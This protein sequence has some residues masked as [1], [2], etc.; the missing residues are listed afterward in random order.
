[1]P[2]KKRPGMTGVY[3]ELPDDL[4][5]KLTGLVDD[6]PIG[7]KADH[8]RLAIQRH[9]DNPPT[10]ECPELPPVAVPARATRKK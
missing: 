7:S 1:M 6:L 2:P 8:I 10:V 3:V 5:A 9:C 4:L